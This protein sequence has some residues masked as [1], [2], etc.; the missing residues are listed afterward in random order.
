LL[1]VE[2]FTT[3]PESN[4]PVLVSNWSIGQHFLALT[5]REIVAEIP[6]IFRKD[7]LRELAACR[8]R[9]EDPDVADSHGSAKATDL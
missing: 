6:A 4:S 5:F 3:N 7:E 8:S 2:V 1:G 9:Q